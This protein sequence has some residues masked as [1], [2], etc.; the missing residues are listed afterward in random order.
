MNAGPTEAPTLWSEEPTDSATR[1][2]VRARIG[3]LHCSLCTGTIE[4][5]LGRRPG[6]HKVSVSLTHEQALIEFDPTVISAEALMGTL[7]EIGYTLSDPRKVEPFEAQERALVRERNRF[8]TALS[9]S[10]AA[11][12]LIAS[13]GNPWGLALSGLVSFSL[14]AF[15]FAVLYHRGIGRASTGALAL[16][17]GGGALFALRTLGPLGGAAVPWLTGA[18]ALALIKQKRQELMPENHCFPSFAT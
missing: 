16:A 6:V 1:R 13:P 17:A 3:G 9:A 15:A 14:I 10:L 11:I 7:T 4:R 5:A 2:R 18:L 8:L 12:G